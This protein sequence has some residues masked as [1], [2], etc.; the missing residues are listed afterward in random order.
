MENT[1]NP[2]SDSIVGKND[3]LPALIGNLK[4]SLTRIGSRRRTEKNNRKPK[5][6]KLRN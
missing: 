2:I 6:L 3:V 4:T 5:K 1:R